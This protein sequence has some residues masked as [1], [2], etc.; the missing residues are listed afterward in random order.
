MHMLVSCAVILSISVHI[1]NKRHYF[2]FYMI[3]PCTV[4][5]NSSD[6]FHTYESEKGNV[7][8]LTHFLHFQTNLVNTEKNRT[9]LY[10]KQL[11]GAFYQ[12]NYIFV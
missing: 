11:K 2:R 4:I 10:F 7:Y 12:K 1:G 6:I 9:R 3:N 5:Q 8:K